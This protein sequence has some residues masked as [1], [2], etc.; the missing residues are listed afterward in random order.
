MPLRKLRTRE[1]VIADLGVNYVERQ[2]LLCGGS[3]QRIYSRKNLI[4]ARLLGRELPD[5]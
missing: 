5:A 2:V 1:H 4:Q 3:V